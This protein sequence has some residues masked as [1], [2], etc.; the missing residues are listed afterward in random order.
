MNVG[1]DYAAELVGRVVKSLCND[2]LLQLESEF[3]EKDGQ[4]F[5]P[6]IFD[7]MHKNHSL[8]TLGLRPTP[9]RQLFYQP[10]RPLKLDIGTPGML[11][12]LHFVDD[13]SALQPLAEN[14]VEIKV[15]ANSLN[16]L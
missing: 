4:L 5:V 2:D 15:Q 16:F 12:S 1:T 10:N 6:R 11:D 8:Q 7:E 14:D 9:E 3:C 13:P